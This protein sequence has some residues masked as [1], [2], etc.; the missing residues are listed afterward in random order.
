MKVIK[1]SFSAAAVLVL[2]AVLCV[3]MAA[4][5]FAACSEKVTLR[6]VTGDGTRLESVEGVVGASYTHPKAPEREGY[7]FDGW[8]LS[9]EC[10]GEPQELP[11]EIP[12]KSCTYYAKY[13]RY[14]VLELD[15]CGGTLAKKKHELK[16]ETVLSDYL[17]AYIPQ[18]EGLIF[19]GWQ[20][21]DGTFLQ[22]ADVMR[23]DLKLT[24]C[25]EA[26][27]SVNVYLQDADDP[28]KFEKS[29]EFS[30][31]GT[32]R[33]GATLSFTPPEPAHFHLDRSG[34]II[35][36]CILRAGENVLEF[37]YLRDEVRLTCILAV[38]NGENKTIT[39]DSRYGAHIK[40]PGSGITADGYEFFGWSDKENGPAIF[41]QGRYI[42][43]TQDLTFYGSWAKC[44]HNA[45]GGGTLA[46]EEYAAGKWHRVSFTTTDGDKVSGELDGETG[47]FTAGGI[48]GRLDGRGGFLLDDSGV[49]VGYGLFLGGADAETFGTLTLSFRTGTAEYLLG[50]EGVPGEYEYEWDDEEK[51]Y[52]GRYLFRGNGETSFLFILNGAVFL[53]EGEERGSYQNEHAEFDELI[54]DGFGGAALMQSGQTLTGTYRGSGEGDWQFES[55]E[56][57]F[58]FRLTEQSFMV[59][60]SAIFGYFAGEYGSA[61]ELDGYGGGVYIMYDNM[62]REVKVFVFA[63]AENIV[64][65]V[66][67]QRSLYFRL[68]YD[69]N[70]MELVPEKEIEALHGNAITNF[71]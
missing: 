63:G 4:L 60:D 47:M 20:Y 32:D 21:G 27:Y 1:K 46:V 8:Y 61:L 12:A 56:K 41:E 7:Y 25:Y 43:L 42:Q 3:F 18:K 14:L 51:I 52:T 6:F 37:Y 69:E 54:L 59:L 39:L 19:G 11:K 29:A 23:A 70:R 71:S 38:P 67:G 50:G 64:K 13:V 31:Q 33:E 30:I 53:R 55:D 34:D 9:S 44:Y 15:P 45:R 65:V 2:G 58:R 17:T 49:Y 57:T 35:Y 68:N 36:N 26:A 48:F 10:S 16:P 66:L 28:E 62:P 24:A 40:L 5:L 22:D